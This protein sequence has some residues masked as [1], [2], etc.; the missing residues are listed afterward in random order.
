[1]RAWCFTCRRQQPVVEDSLEDF[2][3]RRGFILRRVQR[4]ACG[5][6]VTGGAQ[7][8]TPA[9]GL[10]ARLADPVPDPF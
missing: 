2:L 4:L 10:P 6:V 7:R 1:M 5:H 3:S 8:V 9:P